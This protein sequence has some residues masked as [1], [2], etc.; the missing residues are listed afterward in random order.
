MTI[1]ISLKG[2]RTGRERSHIPFNT[3]ECNFKSTA[4]NNKEHLHS[5]RSHTCKCQHIIRMCWDSMC[6]WF[7]AWYMC[8]G[9]IFLTIL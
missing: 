5:P 9:G 1:Y 6:L 8:T 7:V 4:F 2:H 3:V